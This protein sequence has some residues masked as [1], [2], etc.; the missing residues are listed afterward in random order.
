MWAGAECEQHAGCLGRLDLVSPSLSAPSSPLTLS[1]SLLTS[2][3]PKVPHDLAM[4]LDGWCMVC[5]A[6]LLVQQGAGSEAQVQ[7]LEARMLGARRTAHTLWESIEAAAAKRQAAGGG[8]E[9]DGAD[10]LEVGM[11][12]ARGLQE[13]AGVRQVV[14]GVVEARMA[15]EEL[16]RKAVADAPAGPE[17][18]AR[19]QATPFCPPASPSIYTS[20]P[21]M[22]LLCYQ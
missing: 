13:L 1:P 6:R 15:A 19:Q 2:C 8:Q 16:G 17:Q 5:S 4:A 12:D 9:G 21:S 3:G 20:P 22:Y 7:A 14:R 11:L 10:L 18:E